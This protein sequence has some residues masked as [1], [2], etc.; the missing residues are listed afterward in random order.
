[1]LRD[2]VTTWLPS[3][4]QQTY[5]WGTASS[6]LTAVILPIFS[7][8][9]FQF[10]A[11]LYRSV[12]RNPMLCAGAFFALGGVF[13][14]VL[15]AV[16][17]QNAFMSVLSAAILTGA[18]HGVNLMLI[19]MVPPFFK[20]WGLTGTASGVLNSCTYIG[21]AVFTYGVAALSAALGWKITVLIWLGIALLGASVCFLCIRSF[22]KQFTLI[23]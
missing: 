16:T 22:K 6:I 18:M 23:D 10:A 12:L 8:I 5:Q 19:T 15:Y 9:S 21:S 11:R 1:M 20:R 7:I 13:A 17:G 4:I 2:G 14:G 3:Y